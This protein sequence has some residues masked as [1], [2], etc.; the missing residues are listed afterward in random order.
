MK[1]LLFSFVWLFC[2][3]LLLQAQTTVTY[4]DDFVNGWDAYIGQKVTFTNRFYLGGFNTEVREDGKSYYT[5][6]ALLMQMRRTPTDIATPGTPE[7]AKAEAASNALWDNQVRL[8]FNSGNYFLQRI[9]SYVDNLTATVESAG[10]LRVNHTNDVAWQPGRPTRRPDLGNAEIVVAGANLEAFSPFIDEFKSD[11]APQTQEEADLKTAKAIAALRSMDADIYAFCELQDL[12]TVVDFIAERLNEAY[13]TPGLYAGLNDGLASSQIG[14]GRTGYVYRTT[15]VKPVGEMGFP[16]P[17]NYVYSRHQYVQHFEQLSNGGCF[18]LSINHFKAKTPNSDPERVRNMNCLINYLNGTPSLDE[19]V[20][21]MGDL[22]TYNKEEPIVMIEREGYEN[23]LTRYNPE[24]FSYVYNNEVGNMDHALA[25][26]SLTTQVTGAAV[27]QL[28]AEENWN[29]KMGGA[30]VSSDMYGYSDHNPVLVGLRLNPEPEKEC[31]N[32]NYSETFSSSLGAF[33]SKNILGT[34]DWY[35]NKG[36]YANM[37]GFSGGNNPNEDWL[38]SPAFDLSDKSDA[39]LS[40]EHTIGYCAD[41][42][43]MRRNHTLQVTDQY[44][45]NPTTTT[46]TQ[47]DIPVMPTGTNATYVTPTIQLPE[48]ML[49]EN[50]RFAFKYLSDNNICGNWCIRNLVFKANCSNSNINYVRTDSGLHWFAA[51]H[52]LYIYDL[53]AGATVTLYDMVGKCIATRNAN[54]TSIKLPI[55]ANGLY[56]VIVEGKVHKIMIR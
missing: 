42:E 48:N 52:T 18:A 33:T 5:D 11:G 10:I 2:S 12:P 19:D 38:I 17:S 43:V 35:C 28:N 3:I 23:L 30:L 54:D 39:T 24:G 44:T 51:D 45:G 31:E 50:V 7:Y 32:I 13:A 47:L 25:S 55:P 56:I 41:K 46:W 16:D 49:K 15:T 27:Y 20:L 6:M 26:A 36:G 8:F 9:G 22:N 29:Y 1:K 40:F 37:N 34:K 53:P 21:V 4:P 14:A